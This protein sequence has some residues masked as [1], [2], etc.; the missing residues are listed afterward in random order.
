MN[1]S[2]VLALIAAAVA[3]A[4]AGRHF[5]RP[6]MEGHTWRMPKSLGDESR[7]HVHEMEHFKKQASLFIDNNLA[8]MQSAEDSAQNLEEAP[9]LWRR[10]DQNNKKKSKTMCTQEF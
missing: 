8:E 9:S 7:V 3:V 4:S 1:Y 2:L 5:K 10:R 6:L